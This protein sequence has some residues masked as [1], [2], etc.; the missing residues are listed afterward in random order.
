MPMLNIIPII[1]NIIPALDHLFGACFL[2]MYANTIP[3]IPITRPYA[4]ANKIAR[5]PKITP[6]KPQLFDSSFDINK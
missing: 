2:W 3:T 4:D 1:F 6:I 5:I